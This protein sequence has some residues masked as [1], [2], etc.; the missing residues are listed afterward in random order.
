MAAYMKH[1]NELNYDSDDI[2]A[3]MQ[4]TL[5]KLL[6]NNLSVDDL[7]NLTLKLVKL[8]LMVWHF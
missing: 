1:A 2:N 5:A 3:F 4:D 8:A 6:D 7:V